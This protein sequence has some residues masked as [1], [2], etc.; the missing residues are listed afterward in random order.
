MNSLLSTIAAVMIALPLVVA[1]PVGLAAQEDGDCLS[2]RQI[3]EAISDGAILDLFQA[4]ENAGVSGK[5]LS[6]PEVCN[7]GGERQ[8]RVNIMNE[9]GEAERIVLN[10]QAN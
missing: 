4:M 3:Q 10:A 1:A 8:Y 6:E 5:P 7:I 9:N 2:G